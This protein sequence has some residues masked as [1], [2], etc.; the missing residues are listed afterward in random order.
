M[1]IHALLAAGGG[2]VEGVERRTTGPKVEVATPVIFNR[3]AEKVRGFITA[4]RLFLRMKLREATV[5]EQ[6]Q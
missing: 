2:E 4:Y 6:V 3:E 5:E 1:Q